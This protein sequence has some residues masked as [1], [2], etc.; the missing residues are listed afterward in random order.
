MRVHYNVTAT[1]YSTLKVFELLHYSG[2]WYNLI[3]AVARPVFSSSVA[4]CLQGDWKKEEKGS[5][6]RVRGRSDS[7]D[8]GRRGSSSAQ[9]V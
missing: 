1:D 2:A 3:L 5:R 7:R 9:Q 6:G 8:E 4:Y